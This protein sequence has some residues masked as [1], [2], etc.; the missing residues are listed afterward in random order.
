MGGTAL[1]GSLVAGPAVSASAAEVPA[2]GG[3]ASADFS[4][5]NGTSQQ[6]DFTWTW[7]TANGQV[8][9]VY[10]NTQRRHSTSVKVA[11]GAVTKVM[12]EKN[13]GVA[14]AHRNK[15]LTGNQSFWNVY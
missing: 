12:K 4:A 9:S 5:F 11:G 6:A 2:Q 13:Q 1:V 8:F 7:G 3:S 14:Y 15:T 10:D